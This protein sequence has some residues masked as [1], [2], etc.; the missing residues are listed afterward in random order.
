MAAV[1]IKPGAPRIRGRVGQAEEPAEMKG[2][3]FFEVFVTEI[4]AG[5]PKD[6]I[7]PFGPYDT[8]VE[9]QEKLRGACRMACEEIEK[10]FAGG[11][12]GKVLDMKDNK[13]KSWDE[14]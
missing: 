8:E 11:V 3:W 14:T 10:A 12:S 9:A 4:G 5:E 6:P 13:I 2:K 7:G 1:G